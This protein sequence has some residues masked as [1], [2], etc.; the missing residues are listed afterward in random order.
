MASKS[1]VALLSAMLIMMNLYINREVPKSPHSKTHDGVLKPFPDRTKNAVTETR[2]IR[3]MQRTKSKS[4]RPT[5]NTKKC[6]S[7]PWENSGGI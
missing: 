2:Q 1:F 3:A 7:K 6:N 5:L 4:A